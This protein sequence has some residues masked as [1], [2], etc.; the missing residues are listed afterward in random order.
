MEVGVA[1]QVKFKVLSFSV[2][3]QGLA[4]IGCVWQ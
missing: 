4:L 3:M 2:K 1:A